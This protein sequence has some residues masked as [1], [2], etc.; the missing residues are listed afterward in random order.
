VFGLP[1]FGWAGVVWNFKDTTGHFDKIISQLYFRQVMAMLVN[2]PAIIAG[3]YHGAAGLAYGPIPSVP[4]TPHVPSNA[5]KPPYPYNPAKAVAILKAHGGMSSPT[6]RPRV[7]SPAA[8]PTSAV[9]VFPA[10]RR[11]RLTGTRRRP[12]RAL[13]PPHRR[14]G[15]LGG[16]A[17]GGDQRPPAPEDVQLHRH[18]LQRPRPV[19]S[20][21][22][23]TRGRSR[24]SAATPTSPTRRRTPSSTRAA[25]STAA[26]T[27][28][29]RW[30]S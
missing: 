19:G 17:G 12:P 10:G 22:T 6:A 13:R 15:H 24:T 7:P 4:T 9:R 23:S 8:V 5:V 20:P 14:G 1:D 25:R 21:S 26:P 3:I 27:A 16:Q 29:R 11:S 28:I 30:T 2:E 18:Q